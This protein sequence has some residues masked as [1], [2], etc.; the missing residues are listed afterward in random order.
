MDGVSSATWRFDRAT[1]PWLRVASYLVF[2]AFGGLLVTGLLARAGFLR[3]GRLPE[4]AV[5]VA[6]LVAGPALFLGG[7][8]HVRRSRDAPAR[9]D[10]AGGLALGWLAATAVAEGVLVFALVSV[11]GNWSLLT[12]AGL[13]LLAFG[14][15]FALNVL[16]SAGAVDASTRTLE[17]S[18]PDAAIDLG[19]VTDARTVRLGPVALAWLS[20]EAGAYSFADPGTRRF[21]VLSREAADALESVLGTR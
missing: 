4:F 19:T 9:T 11:G 18:D 15:V 2:G 17:L 6:A 1:T 8:W 13:F 14:G 5:L 3:E 20:F 16:T 21:V 7:L 10:D 12:I